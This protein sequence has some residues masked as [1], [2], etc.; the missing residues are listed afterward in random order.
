MD[1]KLKNSWIC[2]DLKK[3]TS[4]TRLRLQGSPGNTSR[5]ESIW[6]DHSNDGSN[7]LCHHAVCG[8]IECVY[9]K[10]IE[11][12]MYSAQSQLAG[13]GKKRDKF[14]EIDIWPPIQTRFV[15]LRPSSYHQ[16]VAL[17]FD[18]FGPPIARQQFARDVRIGDLC[19]QDRATAMA[20]IKGSSLESRVIQVD[21]QSVIR[22]A[23]DRANLNYV[24][25]VIPRSLLIGHD[26]L[27]ADHW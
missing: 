22:G 17:R 8:E 13:D 19:Q 14:A 4:V 7:W 27:V 18:L 25:Y 1:S 3:K 12:D 24:G 6:I 23:L 5:V 20:K 10:T 21:C 11:Y 26:L 16:E 9:D 2:V 15:R